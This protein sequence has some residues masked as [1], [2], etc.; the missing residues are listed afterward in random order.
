GR[1]ALTCDLGPNAP[2]ERNVTLA[3]GTVLQRLGF[4]F[5]VIA[6]IDRRTN[7]F[8]RCTEGQVTRG[9]RKVDGA[10][11]RNPAAART[12]PT[13]DALPFPAPPAGEGFD[14]RV[15][16]DPEVGDA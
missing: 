7:D 2:G 8:D 10:A 16:V 14:G 15:R 12:R 9:T 11:R 6:V 1:V 13:S 4:S 5:E 3:D